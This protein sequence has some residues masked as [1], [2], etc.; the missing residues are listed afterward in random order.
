MD[1][2]TLRK[3]LST[4][5]EGVYYTRIQGYKY[6]IYYDEEIDA[7]VVAPIGSGDPAI[8]G[9]DWSSYQ[10]THAGAIY[11]EALEWADEI[12]EALRKRWMA[13]GPKEL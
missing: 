9:T 11:R 12:D 13:K 3:I 2:R 6:K 5:P 1:K 7:V 4:L 8:S 10:V